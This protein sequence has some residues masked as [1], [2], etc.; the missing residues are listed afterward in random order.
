AAAALDVLD[1]LL[2]AKR[3]EQP[4]TRTILVE[5]RA[6]SRTTRGFISLFDERSTRAGELFSSALTLQP[7]E[8]GAQVG[9]GYL[10]LERGE[11]PAAERA[12]LLGLGEADR[13][14]DPGAG[15]GGYEALIREMSALGLARTEMVRGRP[16]EAL[17][18]YDRILA[19]DA[20][21]VHALVGKASALV[22]LERGDEAR[23]L[24]D[25]V[26]Q[27]DPDNTYART[28]AGI[29]AYNRGD[30]EHA[31]EHFL[32]AAERAGA[33]ATCPHEGLGLVY[34][35]QGR[36]EDASTSFETAIEIDP[37]VDYR[38][39]NGLARIHIDAGDYDRAEA[40][41]L[42]S[43]TNHPGGSEASEL[44]AEIERLRRD[45]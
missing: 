3:D 1:E 33:T 8:V 17:V 27:V 10:Q 16:A 12:F 34:L 25:R 15:A 11:L 42:K 39:Y 28:E 44:L 18:H 35:S 9:Q 36:V 19:A 29:I 21:A 4:Q 30:L 24:I 23:E 14:D 6:R 5:L 7:G 40:L 13:D 38:K 22:S 37:D 20:S 43:R 41:L 26:L 31:E 2:V 32:A 45:R